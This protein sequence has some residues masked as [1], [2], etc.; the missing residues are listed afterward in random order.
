[1][2]VPV[3]HFEISSK[4]Y[5]KAAEFYRNL[6]NW[7]ISEPEG[8]RYALVAGEGEGSIGGGIAPAQPGMAAGVTFYV[9]VEGL[10]TYLD[11]AESLGG[12]TVL[13]PT[14]IPNVGSCALFSDPD[15]NVIGLF[16]SEG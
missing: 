1:M 13:P 9:S 3:V 2:G 12:K 4:D 11:R 16:K 7:K 8:M 14:P 6:F 15:G 10:Q 5:K